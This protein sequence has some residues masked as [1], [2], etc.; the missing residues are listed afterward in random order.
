MVL[1]EL[2]AANRQT[3][4]DR[5]TQEVRDSISGDSV[6]TLE[7]IDHIPVF[8][9]EIIAALQE[10]AG[11]S[12]DSPLPE[13]SPSAAK[14]GIARLR[15]GFD[16]DEVVREYGFLRDGV[17]ALIDEANLTV[18][19]REFR[20]FSRYISN[21]NAEA[22]R[23]FAQNRDTELRTQAAQHF[24]FLA[25]DLRNR[26]S[27]A[28]VALAV[29]RKTEMIANQRALDAAE[30]SLKAS[31]EMID[32][33]LNQMRERATLDP[34][35]VQVNLKALLSAIQ[36]ESTADALAKNIHMTFELLE[37]LNEI[38]ADRRLLHSAIVNLL[39]NALKF[40][41]SGGNVLL[42]A[43]REDRSV[44]IEVED[45]CGGLPSGMVDKLFNPYVQIGI[46]RSGFGLGLA[47]AKQAAQLHGG[48]VEAR[49]IQGRG[50]VFQLTLPQ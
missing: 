22:I 16:I 40:T 43:F 47:I 49:D 35:L 14:H 4:I 34:L 32:S 46:D 8:I 42:R 24:S 21:G 2:L 31:G 45:E 7:L 3:L 13:V 26:L 1:L 30:R 33:A 29:L 20:T 39:G 27:S 37:P 41:P 50:C 5:W 12:N 10:D 48:N 23:Q 44:T 18:T 15:L 25:H 36:E 11:I 17:L 19:V 9:E 6:P 38:R 28:R